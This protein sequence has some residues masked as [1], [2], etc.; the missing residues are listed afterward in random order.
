MIK[1]SGHSRNGH[2]YVRDKRANRAPLAGTARRRAAEDLR[3][4]IRVGPIPFVRVCQVLEV[5]R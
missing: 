2:S 1:R 4:D 3:R 5:G